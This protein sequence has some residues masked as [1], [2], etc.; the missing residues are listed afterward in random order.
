MGTTRGARILLFLIFRPSV[1]Q[2]FGVA[3]R[4]V[5]VWPWLRGSI[6]PT[7]LLLFIVSDCSLFFNHQ[8]LVPSF[9]SSTF[10][11]V[12]ISQAFR[13]LGRSVLYSFL[14]IP[15]FFLTIFQYFHALASFLFIVYSR[16]LSISLSTIIFTILGF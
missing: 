13:F 14:S 12:M 1:Y 10:L 3:L 9:L 4:G 16:F 7:F 2:F 8:F 6:C 11:L 15:W 5:G